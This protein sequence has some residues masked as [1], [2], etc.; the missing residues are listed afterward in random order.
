VSEAIAIIPPKPD[1]ARAEVAPL[2]RAVESMVVVT[3]VEQHEAA[4]LLLAD[5][6]RAE[7]RINRL[8]E[9]AVEAA[10]ESKRKAE[11]TRQE[12]VALRDSVLSSVTEARKTISA[13]CAAFEAEER[14]VA[15]LNQKAIEREAL[16]RQEQERQFDAAMAET[17]EAAED[18]LT[19]PLPAPVVP[20]VRP[21]VARVA[22]VSTRETWA[23]EITDKAAFLA[24]AAKPENNYMA[25]PNMTALN[26]R[27]R[28][29]HAEMKIPGVKA[30]SSLSHS[31]R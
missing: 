24:W 7:T 5:A 22:G 23:A 15:E 10:K 12:V 25:E 14:R 13:R 21:E 27:A 16:A 20:V 9:P 8:F 6:M 18:A 11:A 19:E 31:R 29:E 2:L 17:E 30:V 3:N 4:L 28:A 1:D 26:S